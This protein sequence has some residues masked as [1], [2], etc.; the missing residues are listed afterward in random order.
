MDPKI[1]DSIKE[2]VSETGQ[3]EA[4]ARLIISWFRAIALEE[5]NI[6]NKEHTDRRLE[7]LYNEVE[8]SE[9]KNRSDNDYDRVP[10]SLG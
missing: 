2:A 1:N 4:L 5:E 10:E 9:E 6:N 3:S 7:L 8:M